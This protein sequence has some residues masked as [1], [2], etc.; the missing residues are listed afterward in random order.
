MSQEKNVP[1]KLYVKIQKEVGRSN[2]CPFKNL[3]T[4]IKND[5]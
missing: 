1:F 3:K 2:I 5:N 4:G